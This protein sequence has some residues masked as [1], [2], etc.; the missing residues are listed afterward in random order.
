MNHWDKYIIFILI[1]DTS[2]DVTNPQ[3]S[4]SPHNRSLS[5]AIQPISAGIPDQWIAFQAVIQG[6]KLFY[7]ATLASLQPKSFVFSWQGR[8][9]RD[10]RL[11]YSRLLLEFTHIAG[12]HT[13]ILAIFNIKGKAYR[14]FPGKQLFNMEGETMA[15]WWKFQPNLFRKDNQ[16]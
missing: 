8:A 2:T 11:A 7:L 16:H 10:H 6:H 14:K 1:I 15:Y 3:I 12:T 4:V 9:G 5:I 13:P